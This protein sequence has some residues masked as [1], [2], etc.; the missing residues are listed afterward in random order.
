MVT[1]ANFSILRQ[2]F[3]MDKPKPIRDE[4]A[5]TKAELAEELMEDYQ[6]ARS[7]IDHYSRQLQDTLDFVKE[8]EGDFAAGA[9]TGADDEQH[10]QE[11]LERNRRVAGELRQV[12][13]DNERCQASIKRTVELL[14]S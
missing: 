11:V 7:H 5:E 12:I 8:L 9:F 10:W 3:A 13:H 6:L 1:L 2:T 4:D 14:G